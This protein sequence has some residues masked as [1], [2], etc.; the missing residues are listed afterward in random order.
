MSSIHP[1]LY[2]AKAVTSAAATKITRLLTEVSKSQPTFRGTL[3]INLWSPYLAFG[4]STELE[5]PADTQGVTILDEHT[6]K[7]QLTR[8]HRRYFSLLGRN[9]SANHLLLE[10]ENIQTVI[11]DA[12]ADS[13]QGPNIEADR[14][15]LCIPLLS[16]G[17]DRCF[18]ALVPVDR[19]DRWLVMLAHDLYEQRYANLLREELLEC[20]QEARQ[21][22]PESFARH[23]YEWLT[24]NLVSEHIGLGHFDDRW[25]SRIQLTSLAALFW[26]EYWVSHR[27]ALGDPAAQ[28]LKLVI[29]CTVTGKAQDRN[30]S[31]IEELKTEVR[32]A[33]NYASQ[34]AEAILIEEL[35]ELFS[36]LGGL[37]HRPWE[38]ELKTISNAFSSGLAG[39][40]IGWDHEGEPIHLNGL[41]TSGL[42]ALPV[43]PTQLV[44][45][46][47]IDPSLLTPLVELED[48]W[49]L[50]EAY[51][52]SNDLLLA[53]DDVA[54]QFELELV[55]DGS[56][57]L[58]VPRHVVELSRQLD[59]FIPALGDP[60]EGLLHL[61]FHTDERM[62][63]HVQSVA[64]SGGQVRRA[65][66]QKGAK[67]DWSA[68][69][70]EERD[71][72]L[73]S[74]AVY[75]S[76]I[77]IRDNLGDQVFFTHA[78]ATLARLDD[79]QLD[80]L[81]DGITEVS[82]LR[83]G[84]LIFLGPVF[85]KAADSSHWFWDASGKSLEITRLGISFRILSQIPETPSVEF[86]RRFA[87]AA[88]MDGETIVFTAKPGTDMCP[89]GFTIDRRPGGISARQF[90]QLP[91]GTAALLDAAK[92]KIAGTYEN[93][94]K[95]SAALIKRGY[96]QGRHEVAC[97][98]T[99]ELRKT[100]LLSLGTR[101]RKAAMTTMS[102]DSVVGITCSASGP[103]RIWINGVPIVEIVPQRELLLPQFGIPR[104]TIRKE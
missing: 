2:A 94:W 24:R 49:G 104:A 31:A 57:V 61:G 100:Q 64:G 11:V 23:L 75:E 48:P 67:F 85:A 98:G 20:R 59:E 25:L 76:L 65:A 90:V 62:A 47:E 80:Q 87:D 9:L 28:R 46:H 74:R 50:W 29:S 30:P 72:G 99:S 44:V 53:R 12:L 77:L 42:D 19:R 16:P 17:A 55:E 88:A 91:Q 79:G 5:Y 96:V 92:P 51:F 101:H 8:I 40:L 83:R 1:L 78:A 60:P 86:R 38:P 69:P 95:Q 89:E 56:S 82:R 6:D 84:C 102:L 37:E 103:I 43:A 39:E 54:L 18:D 33:A 10:I 15:E 7:D 32:R 58:P 14:V 45:L 3:A 4:R 97:R 70:A 41:I 81:A 13:L 66:Q 68:I 34:Q 36:Q 27:L 52:K 93:N 35:K 73:V 21:S 71:W 26:G 63:V 22:L